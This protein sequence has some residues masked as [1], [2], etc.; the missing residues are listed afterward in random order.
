MRVDTR[1]QGIVV[2]VG[3][4]DALILLFIDDFVVILSVG[5]V[6]KLIG[7]V[8][9]LVWLANRA[10]DNPFRAICGDD[11]DASRAN[12]AECAIDEPDE[13]FRVPFRV[14]ASKAWVVFYECSVEPITKQIL[15][16]GCAVRE[17]F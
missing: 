6:Q 8:R 9:I 4:D 2:V 16:E 17:L 13:V 12:F 1:I 5:R 3:A 10:T 11:S 14:V 15:I 7:Q